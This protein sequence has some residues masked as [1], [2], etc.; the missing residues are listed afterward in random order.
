MRARPPT[1]APTPA[2]M[3]TV[4]DF[5]VA[6][7]GATGDSVEGGGVFM[8][9]GTPETVAVESDDGAVAV[10]AVD[11]SM[12]V[13]LVGGTDVVGTTPIVVNTVGA[14]ISHLISITPKQMN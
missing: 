2:A 14:S 5:T 4:L 13:V 8:T 12:D 10:V 1:P 6:A 11:V 9:V 7:G 3:G